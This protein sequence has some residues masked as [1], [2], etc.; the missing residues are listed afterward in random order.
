MQRN[1]E[2]MLKRVEAWQRSQLRDVTALT[3]SPCGE[4]LSR[5]LRT[6]A[7]SNEERHTCY[8]MLMF[9]LQEETLTTVSRR[10]NSGKA[11]QLTKRGT[12]RFHDVLAW[13]EQEGLLRGER[14]KVVRGRMPEAL[15]SE[16]KKKTGIQSDTDL[17]EVALANIAV[18][19]DYA[20]WLLSRRGAVDSEVS[21]E[22]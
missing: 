3:P 5:R 18:G 12:R 2:P 6:V 4:R 16:A 21:L 11:S 14:T 1:F 9:V 19:D 7:S 8:N 13:A 20:E 17:I 22:Y 10:K 15:V